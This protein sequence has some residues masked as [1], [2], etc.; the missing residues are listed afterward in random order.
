MSFAH[1]LLLFS[2]LSLA[3]ILFWM[4]WQ[5]LKEFRNGKQ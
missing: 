3:G 2:F 5:L 1:A 4:A